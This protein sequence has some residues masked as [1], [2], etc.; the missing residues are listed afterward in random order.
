VLRSSLKSRLRSGTDGRRRGISA[1]HAIAIQRRNEV[2]RHG[3]YRRS[4]GS[5]A[6]PDTAICR[7][8]ATATPGGSLRQR[9]TTA[10]AR[11]RGDARDQLTAMQRAQRDVERSLGD[12]ELDGQLS[13][14]DRA[15][16]SGR[17]RRE[18]RLLAPCQSVIGSSGTHGALR[19]DVGAP[20]RTLHGPPTLGT[21]RYTDNWSMGQE[22]IPASRA[23]GHDD[24][25]TVCPVS[26][27]V[28]APPPL[29]PARR[30]GRVGSRCPPPR[31]GV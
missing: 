26:W 23:L 9:P 22:A 24:V 30:R 28:R 11:G 8:A 20:K 12:A 31:T 17:N 1:R 21:R 14:R 15:R 3:T 19:A 4:S 27:P 29:P 2:P 10:P 6:G 5:A 25:A 16:V 7:T 18:R 13:G